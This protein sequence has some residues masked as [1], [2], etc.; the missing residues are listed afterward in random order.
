MD[1]TVIT[2]SY[3]AG[4]VDMG[5]PRL[6]NHPPI[7]AHMHPLRPERIAGYGRGSGVFSV[8]CVLAAAAGSYDEVY[9]EHGAVGE[10]FVVECVVY[11]LGG[12]MS[13][14]LST[15][16]VTVVS[17]GMMTVASSELSLLVIASSVGM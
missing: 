13:G 2:H 3:P 6:G 17:S 9:V 10:V 1:H 5:G 8:S 4:C 12:E 15:G 14:L 11:C 7:T 16:A